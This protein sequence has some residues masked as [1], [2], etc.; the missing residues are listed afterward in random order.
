MLTEEEAL[1][2][3]DYIRNTAIAYAA[4]CAYFRQPRPKAVPLINHFKHAVFLAKADWDLNF[5]G[6]E[7]MPLWRRHDPESYKE[8]LID[9]IMENEE[10]FV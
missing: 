4:V 7:P 2:C 5:R 10:Q 9:L 6:K 8:Q 1:E 3:F